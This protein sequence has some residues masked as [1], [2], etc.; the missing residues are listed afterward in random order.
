[1][2]KKIFSRYNFEVTTPIEY[3]GM[4]SV[5]LR[6]I[7]KSITEYTDEEEIE[8][9]NA[10]NEWARVESIYRPTNTGRMLKMKFESPQMANNATQNGMI[11]IIKRSCQKIW[12]RRFL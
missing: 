8:S 12:E 4:R 3:S 1:M 11:M 6:H 7:D 2:T 9:I 10:S 5:I